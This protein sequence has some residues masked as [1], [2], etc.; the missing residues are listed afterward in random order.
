VAKYND[1]WLWPVQLELLRDR[2]RE[3]D[4]T[5]DKKS[6]QLAGLQVDK[7]RLETELNEV[8][9]RTSSSDRQLGMLK[10]KVSMALVFVN[11][12]VLFIFCKVMHL[13]VLD[14]LFFCLFCQ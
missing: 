8:S 2:L 11:Q 3:K 5:L 4:D 7:K 10:R 9:D 13:K 12:I 1:R 14:L 6:K